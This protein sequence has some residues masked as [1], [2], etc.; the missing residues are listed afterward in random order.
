MS[1]M[2]LEAAHVSRIDESDDALFYASPRLVKHIDEPA[3][4]ALENWYRDHL[5]QNGSILDMMSSWVSH[6]PSDIKYDHICGMGMNAEELKENA[7]LDKWLIQDLNETPIL[8]FGDQAFDACTIAVSVQYLKRP[9]EVFKEIS[10][11]LKPG[12]FAAISFSN[13]MF[14]T[15]AIALWRAATGPVDH[16]RVVS[17]YFKSSGG[18]EQA[19]IFDISPNPFESDPIY[20]VKARVPLAP[21][22]I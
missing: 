14:P 9:T 4:H 17:W 10:R 5:P 6:F 13:R 22:Q 2:E 15:K 8:P 7:I 20:V 3:C 21:G 18:F 1:E 19:E 11:I 16:A 12:A